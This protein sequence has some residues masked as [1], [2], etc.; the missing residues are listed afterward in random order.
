MN[1]PEE[2]IRGVREAD[3][4]ALGRAL[5]MELQ[6]KRVVWQKAR[7]RRSTVRMASIFF[8]LLIVLG[9]LFA[10]FYLLPQLRERRPETKSSHLE[11]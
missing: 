6:L 3:P 8:L 7:E 4:D 10:C 2:P 9:V 1:S 5:E 11:P